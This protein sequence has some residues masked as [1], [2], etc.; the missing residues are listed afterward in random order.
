MAESTT[1][2]WSD[3]AVFSAGWMVHRRRILKRGAARSA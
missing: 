3:S 1:E 2:R